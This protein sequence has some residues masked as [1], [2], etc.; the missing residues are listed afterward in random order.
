MS[1]TLNSYKQAEIMYQILKNKGE[2]TLEDILRQFN[3]SVSTAY[4]VQRALRALCENHPDECEI[5]YRDRKTVFKY[6][7]NK[8]N[9]SDEELKEVE[10][11]LNARPEQ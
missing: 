6:K 8:Q 5:E 9:I 10:R 1:R 11:I 2:V 3:V 7:G 4:N